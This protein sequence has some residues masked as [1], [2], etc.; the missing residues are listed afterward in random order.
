MALI[1]F[2][3]LPLAALLGSPRED[4]REALPATSPPCR[5][6]PTGSRTRSPSPTPPSRRSRRSS[7]ADLPDPDGVAIYTDHPRNL[8]TLLGSSVPHQHLRVGHLPLPARDVPTSSSSSPSAWP[9][10]LPP[11]SRPRLRLLPLRAGGQRGSRAEPPLPGR[12]PAPSPGR[13]LPRRDP[14]DGERI[15]ERDPRRAAAHPLALHA[16]R[17]HLFHRPYPLG[18]TVE[19]WSRSPGYRDPGPAEDDAV[20][21]RVHRSRP[22]GDRPE[23]PQTGASTTRRSSQWSPT[24]APPSSPGSRAGCSS[25]ANAGWILRV[26]MFVKLPRPAPRQ[27][28]YAPGADDRPAADDRRRPRDPHPLAG[29]RALAARPG[30]PE[31]T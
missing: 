2:D 22:R 19:R 21:L 28:V 4:R 3:E 17:A 31:R 12:L 29:R 18:L 15:A 7:P 6:S 23:P 16:V 24:T 1:V 26:P 20:Q 5:G 25:E 27:I 13:A 8:F 11:G 30:R 9:R 14:G 10:R